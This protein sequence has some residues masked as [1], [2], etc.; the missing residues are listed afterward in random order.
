VYFSAILVGGK[1]FSSQIPNAYANKTS[2]D[3]EWCC[4][5]PLDDGLCGSLACVDLFGQSAVERMVA[6]FKK[7]GLRNVSVIAG[8]ECISFHETRDMRIA[9]PKS[10]E[11]R[12][13]I[14][15]R[16]LLKDLQRGIDTVLIAQVGAY[17]E[18][19]L[20]AALQFHRAKKQAITPIHDAE[21][22][23]SYWVVDVPRVLS[24]HDFAFPPRENGITS[25]REPYVVAGYVNRLE[26][27]RDFRRLA[28]DA[29]LGRCFITPAGREAR[30]GVW[31]DE[32]A[33][34][35]KTARLVAPCYVG[36][37]ARVQA[38]AVV[39]RSSNLERNCEVGES[40]LVSD[41]SLLPHTMIGRG[42]DVS[43]AVVDRINF[44]D[45][46]RNVTLKIQDPSLISD[47]PPQKARVPAYVP[48]YGDT[49]RESPELDSE[50]AE[51]LTRAKGRLLEVFKGEV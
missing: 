37:G 43:S 42:L 48:E 38:G 51:Y 44:I 7:A 24:G 17:A 20:P 31:I 3:S 16:A 19:D 46:E 10:A 11:D 12:W 1:P 6:R 22:S 5:F 28:V 9:I 41:A 13:P 45:L 49:G 21:G 18:F 27:A 35:H 25:P 14:V 30:P 8:S 33:R 34:V 32:G 23:L 29:F 47:V 36:S 39:T 50:Y 2:S 26:N 40:S 15:K 4:D